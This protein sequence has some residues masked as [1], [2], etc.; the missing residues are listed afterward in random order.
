MSDPIVDLAPGAGENPLARRLERLIRGNLQASDRALRA[1]RALRGSVQI[2]AF[3]TGEALT[4]RFDLGR[5]TI[6]EGNIGIPSV[7]IGAPLQTLE[8][9]HEIPMSHR[10]RI[11]WMR[12]G[13]RRGRRALIGLTQL[14]L[15]GDVKIYGLASH[16]RTV[17]RLLRILSQSC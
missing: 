9:L 5:L 8:R 13:D 16:P 11:P 7:T 14:Y 2:V 12:L 17:S 4:L 6:H 3:D 10:L 15:A 1:F